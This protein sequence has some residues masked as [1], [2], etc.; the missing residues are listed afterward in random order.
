MSVNLKAIEAARD[1]A[2]VAVLNAIPQSIESEAEEIVNSLV[3]L[4][5]ET[6]KQYLDEEMY[7]ELGHH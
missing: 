4:I 1:R 3:D 2:V 6:M 5:F 7:D